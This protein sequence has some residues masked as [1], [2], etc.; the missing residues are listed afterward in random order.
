MSDNP[1]LPSQG[2]IAG[3]PALFYAV[4]TTVTSTP[5]VES[6]VGTLAVDVM[7]SQ[8]NTQLTGAILSRFEIAPNKLS[9]RDQIWLDIERYFDTKDAVID[10]GHDDWFDELRSRSKRRLNDIYRFDERD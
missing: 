9:P 8:L 6:S 1:I 2:K 10:I 7:Y 5:H 3:N 4:G